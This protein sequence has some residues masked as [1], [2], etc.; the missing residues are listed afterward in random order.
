LATRKVPDA[1]W[2]LGFDARGR[3]CISVPGE[4]LPPIKIVTEAEA[5]RALIASPSVEVALISI[6]NLLVLIAASI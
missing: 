1:E 3:L 6:G 2:P 4:P 5:P